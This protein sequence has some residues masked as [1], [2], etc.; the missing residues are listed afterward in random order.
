MRLMKVQIS[1]DIFWG[2]NRY[3][4]IEIF[5]SFDELI[6]YIHNELIT[7]LKENNLISLETRARDLRLHNHSYNNYEDLYKLDINETIYICGHC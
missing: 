5:E 1:D 2:F 3:I 7:F 6:P 4:D